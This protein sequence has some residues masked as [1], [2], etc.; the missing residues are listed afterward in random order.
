MGY[1]TVEV[2]KM[3]GVMQKVTVAEGATVADALEAANLA[4]ETG[5]EIRLDGDVVDASTVIEDGATIVLTKMI[6]GN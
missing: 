4:N 6:K 2:A 1:I 3:P 5:Y